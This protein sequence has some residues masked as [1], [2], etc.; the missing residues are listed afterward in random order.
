MTPAEAYAYGLAAIARHTDE[1]FGRR[2]A[3]LSADQQ[4]EVIVDWTAGEVSAFSELD[5]PLF[6]AMVRANVAEGLFCDPSYG[7]NRGMV[8]WRWLGYPGVGEAHGGYADEIE[9][10]DQPYMRA[11][12]SLDWRE[13]E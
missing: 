2:F 8:G 9:R 3:E 12:R 1:R 11:P 5:G 10:H 13:S 4:E 6:F 7:G